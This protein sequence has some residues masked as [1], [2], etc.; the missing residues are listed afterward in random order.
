MRTA[1]VLAMDRA[2]GRAQLRRRA[3]FCIGAALARLEGA[4]A[5]PRLLTRFPR[6]AP[7]RELVRRDTLLLRGIDT[8]PA[9][10]N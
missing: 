6:I 4:V 10:V 9:T 8:L 1:T 2:W 7:A 3:H 5:F